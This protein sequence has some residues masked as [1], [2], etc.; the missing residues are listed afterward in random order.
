MDEE[1]NPN[2]QD[3][4][5]QLSLTETSFNESDGFDVSTESVV[6]AGSRQLPMSK[7]R[8]SSPC[9]S[10]V[11]NIEDG[12]MHIVNEQDFDGEYKHNSFV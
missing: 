10:G 5:L 8:C 1:D 9:H 12:L 7:P 11:K 6:P 2:S 4:H 3:W